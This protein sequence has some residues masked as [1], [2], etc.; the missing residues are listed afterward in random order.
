ML[1]R[2]KPIEKFKNSFYAVDT[3]ACRGCKVCLE[4][5]CPAISWQEAEG[6]TEDGHKRKGTV[7]INK[8]QCVGCEVCAQVCKFEAIVP[9]GGR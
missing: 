5:R 1:R 2:A 9:G 3:D 4:I 6:Q 8:D 7:S